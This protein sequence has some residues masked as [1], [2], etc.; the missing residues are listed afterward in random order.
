[1]PPH[2]GQVILQRTGALGFRHRPDG[3]VGRWGAIRPDIELRRGSQV[4]SVLDTKYKKTSE[5]SLKNPDFYQ[6]L[7]YCEAE[8]SNL[9]GLIYPRSEYASDDEIRIRNSPIRMHRFAINLAVPSADLIAEAE[10]LVMRVADWVRREE[11]L[12]ESA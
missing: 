9:G 4:L 1:M 12:A 8:S 3:T 11:R 2:L 7:S 6:V 10:R 5:G